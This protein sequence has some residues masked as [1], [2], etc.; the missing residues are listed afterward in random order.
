MTIYGIFIDATDDFDTD[1]ELIKCFKTKE[2]ALNYLI[3][4]AS[5]EESRVNFIIEDNVIM[6]ITYKTLEKG[7]YTKYGFAT[8]YT[9]AYRYNFTYY[10]EEIPMEED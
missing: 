1:K 4:I 3:E 7:N 10:L 5:K 9:E 2:K 6:L 8:D